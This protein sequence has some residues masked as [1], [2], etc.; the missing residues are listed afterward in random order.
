LAVLQGTAFTG[1]CQQVFVGYLLIHYGQ[2]CEPV[3]GS[4]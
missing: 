2:F 4:A 1:W 3:S